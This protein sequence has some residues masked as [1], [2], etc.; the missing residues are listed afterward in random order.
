MTDGQYTGTWRGVYP[1]KVNQQRHVVEEIVE[2]GAPYGIGLEAGSKPELLVALA[3][4]DTPGAT[5]VCNGYKDRAYI[6]TALLAQQLGR[7][8]IIVID[9]VRELE[10][11]IDLRERRPRSTPLRLAA[12]CA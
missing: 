5:I 12:G 7:R 9:R 4:L 10:L 1:I 6:E 2:L 11:L 8:P 3:V